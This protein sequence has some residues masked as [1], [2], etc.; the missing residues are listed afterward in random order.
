MTM[1]TKEL[2]AL[3]AAATPG[4]W[5]IEDRTIYALQ[6]W[7][8]RNG[9]QQVCNRFYATVY[10]Q[11]M[12]GNGPTKEEVDANAALIV[13]AVNALPGLCAEVEALRKDAERLAYIERTFSGMTNRERYLPVTMIWGAGCNGRTLREACDKYMAKEPK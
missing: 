7:G 13:A 9:V 3:V 12:C 8:W 4:P 10:G 2:L 1:T 6:P 5:L 11:T